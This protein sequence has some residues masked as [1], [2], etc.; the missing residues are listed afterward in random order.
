MADALEKDEELVR[1]GAEKVV[2]RG[3]GVAERIRELVPIRV[4]KISCSTTPGTRP[5]CARL[6]EHVE[7]GRLTLRVARILLPTE[8]ADRTTNLQ[9]SLS[10]SGLAAA[11]DHDVDRCRQGKNPGDHSKPES[12]NR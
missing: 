12:T 2:R 3:A 4:H 11:D 7:A 10:L 8:A 6:V 9:G 1:L 5:S